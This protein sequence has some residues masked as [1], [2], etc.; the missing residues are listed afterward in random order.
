MWTETPL[1][2]QLFVVFILSVSIGSFLNVC[3]YRMPR[4]ESIVA[5]R[6]HCTHCKRPIEWYF[7]IPLVSYLLLKGKC[8]HCHIHISSRYFFVEL[9]TG[10]LLTSVYQLSLTSTAPLLFF[11]FYSLFVIGLIVASFIDIEFYLIPDSISLGGIPLGL[12]ASFLIPSV[13]DQSTPLWGLLISLF[14]GF[15]GG[16]LLLAIAV[17]GKMIL[18]KDAM[19]MGDIKLLAMIGTFL[20]IEKVC[21]TLF[22][23]SVVGSLISIPLLLMGKGG[24]KSKLPFGPYLALGALLALFFGDTVWNWYFSFAQ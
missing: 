19:G 13:M 18:K 8:H 24:W 11:V 16:A 23:G 5:P 17:I 7:N 6:S 20:G 9:T 4:N 12:A 21:L 14:S 22:F 15:F 10:I 1:F 3:I 2:F